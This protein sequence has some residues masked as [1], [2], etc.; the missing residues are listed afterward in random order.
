[1]SDDSNGNDPSPKERARQIRR[2]AYREAKER[3]EKDPRY[4]AMKEAA[5]AQRRE[6]YQEAKK[7]RH[8]DAAE[9]KAEKERRRVEA[10]LASDAELAKL[11]RFA[12]KGS[13]AKN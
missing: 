7:Q 6:L 8:A 10:R 13:S 5:R 4:L 2:A 11:L 1:M 3:R 9:Q 12:S